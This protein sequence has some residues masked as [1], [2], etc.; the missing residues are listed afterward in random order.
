MKVLSEF[1]L[2]LS[3]IINTYYLSNNLLFGSFQSHEIL[4]Q[5]HEAFLV[6]LAIEPILL[7]ALP[8]DHTSAPFAAIKLMFIQANKCLFWKRNLTC[9]SS[10]RHDMN[11]EQLF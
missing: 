8:L 7:S 3:D 5:P 9:S 4:M 1:Y 2:G 6:V 10:F 11:F